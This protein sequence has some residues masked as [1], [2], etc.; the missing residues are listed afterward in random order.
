MQ[1]LID[2]FD[3]NNLMPHGYC[4]S[5]SPLLLWLHVASDVLIT[6]SYYSIPLSLLY[7]VRQRKDLPYPWLITMFAVFIVACGTTHILSVVTIWF[8]VYWLEGV[9]KAFTALISVATALAMLWVIPLALKLPSP[10]QL[11]AEIEQKKL[12]DS[13]RQEALE[14]LQKIAGRLPGMVYQFR[15]FAD[16]SATIPYCS[17]GIR[18]IFRLTPE[19]ACADS[20]LLFTLIHSDD[21]DH[22][23]H[24]MQQSADNLTTWLCEFRVSF[25]GG[26]E[27]WLLAN[28][29]PQREQ[30]GS[31]LWHGFISDITER[32]SAETEL[33]IAAAAF[34]S[35]EGMVI[36]DTDSVILRVNAAFTAITGYS[37]D[38]A[39]GRKMS[40]LKSGH[41]DDAFYEAMWDSIVTTGAWQGEIWDRRKNGEVYPN[42]LAI[43][44]V[45]GDDGK[46]SHYVGTHVDITERK[47]T[48]EHIN[49]LAFYDPLTQLPNRRLLQERLKQGI[50]MNRRLSN[51]MAV[52][53]MDLDKFKTVNDTL[54]HTAGDE[55]LQQVAERIQMQLREV[56]M[57]ARLGGDEFVILMENIGHYEHAARVAEAVIHALSQ[58]F[59]LCQSYDVV[60]GTSIGIAIHPQHGDTLEALMDNADTALYHAKDQGRGCFA[61]FSE[62]LTQKARERI[63]LESRL[64][65]AIEQRELRVYFQPQIDI[66]SGQIIGAEALVRWHDP[67]E[68]CLMP[69]TFIAL[70]EETGLIVGIGE[71]VLRETCKIGQQWLEQGLSPITLAVNVSP[72]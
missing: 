1:L 21:Y 61:Y 27:H 71:W 13:A 6:L 52:L 64:R 55:L 70:A 49:R 35:Q 47:A 23:V 19:Q 62:E 4:L 31:T 69:S 7:F 22:V 72:Q 9:I 65:R 29:L 56:D 63:V 54:G 48:E 30:D 17:D 59:T 2:F 39:V 11:Q 68:G 25:A 18:D 38:E 10:A 3:M 5:W 42:W 53:M 15:L 26:V 37:S 16:G 32:K 67:V 12:A 60:I 41:H 45:K 44:A 40:L 20:R 36:T 66:N 57:V 14:R 24:S 8:P 33:R 50:K 34:D 43:T 51:Q 46:V 28:A 58:P